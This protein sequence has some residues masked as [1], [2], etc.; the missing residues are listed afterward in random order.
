MCFPDRII[1]VICGKSKVPAGCAGRRLRLDLSRELVRQWRQPRP[2]RS[3]R[4]RHGHE[5]ALWLEKFASILCSVT[6]ATFALA[7][8]RIS[9]IPFIRWDEKA[10]LQRDAIRSQR[11]TRSRRNGK[12]TGSRKR[13]ALFRGKHR[14]VEL[15][16]KSRAQPPSPGDCD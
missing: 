10:G 4:I 13:I 7:G 11:L 6:P 12:E 1:S 2:Q 9:R 16:T 5:R 3:A 8:G 14:G 15:G